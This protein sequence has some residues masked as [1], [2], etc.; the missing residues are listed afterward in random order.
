MCVNNGGYNIELAK[1]CA[2]R[3][4]VSKA[5]TRGQDSRDS[6]GRG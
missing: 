4:K 3:A 1:V 6:R 5:T 2:L